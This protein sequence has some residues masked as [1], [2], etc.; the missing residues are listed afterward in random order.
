MYI[1]ANII[2]LPKLIPLDGHN[3]HSVVGQDN[4]AIHHVKERTDSLCD[5]FVAIVLAAFATISKQD[6]VRWTRNSGIHN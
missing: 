1:F 5:R 3:E 6:C 2:L 4:C